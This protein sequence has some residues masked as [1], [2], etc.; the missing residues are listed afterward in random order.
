MK[1]DTSDAD[2][3]RQIKSVHKAIDIVHA[4]KDR[5]GATLQ[6]LTDDLELTKSTI[7][8]YLATLRQEGIVTQE[9]DGTYQLGYWVIP[10]SNYARNNTDLYR[11]GRDEIDELADQTRHTAHLVTESNGNQIVLYEAMGEDAVTSDYHLRMRETPRQLY[12]SA[13][14]KSILAFLPEERRDELIARTEF[15]D[16]SNAISD[17]GTL[18]EQLAEIRER[19]YAVNDEEEIRGTRSIGAPVRGP[20]EAVAGAVSVTAPKT[21]LQNAQFTDEVPE[22][23]ME[24]ANIIEVKIETE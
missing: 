2:E 15:D 17:R 18:R 9:D 6:E 3:P 12:T 24:A 22:L 1:P 19:G 21:R 14:G 10:I 7:Y 5:R 11:I 13:A 8:T 20:G 23:V 4:I 16:D